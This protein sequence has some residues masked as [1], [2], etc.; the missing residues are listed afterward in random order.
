MNTHTDG[1]A[2]LNITL[3]KHDETFLKRII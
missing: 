2:E 1:V 3:R